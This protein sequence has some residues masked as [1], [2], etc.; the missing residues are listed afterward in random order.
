MAVRNIREGDRVIITDSPGYPQRYPHFNQA[1]MSE[2]L[3]K[4]AIVTEVI[5][6]ITGSSKWMTMVKLDIDE[7]RFSWATRWLNRPTGYKKRATRALI[8]TKP[9]T[10]TE[11]GIYEILG[12]D[13]AK[14]HIKVAI[15]RNLPVL[16]VGDTGTGKTTIVKDLAEQAGKKYLRFNLTGETTVDEFVG[17]YVLE[18]GE[19]NWQDGVLLY[20]MKQGL[21]LI[22]DEVNVALP[23]ILFVLHSLLDDEQAVLVSQHESEVVRPHQDFRFFGTMNPVDEYAGTKDLNKAFKSRFGMILQLDYP[24]PKIET[25]VVERKGNTTPEVASLLVDIGLAIRRA[26]ARDEV[27]YTCSTRDLIQTAKLVEPLGLQ[28]A[29]TI[30]LVN[31]A[32]GDTKA[33]QT[34]IKNLVADYETAIEQRVELNIEH[35]ITI[36]QAKERLLEQ[37]TKLKA[38]WQ[39]ELEAKMAKTKTAKTK[40]KA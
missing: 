39:A 22:V 10:K 9:K 2:Y 25:Q 13:K 19:T 14:K 1:R 32:N 8:P 28:D 12:Q 33:I 7:G 31:K 35:A 24:S 17:K 37:E 27:F 16:L 20:A 36:H 34:I 6:S 5:R 23:E 11:M 15:E 3:G 40:V 26:K 30:G 29:L 38:Q 18:A 21:W 4:E